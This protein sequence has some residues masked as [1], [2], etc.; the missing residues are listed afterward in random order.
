MSSF[1][2]CKPAWHHHQ[3]SDCEHH[4]CKYFIFCLSNNWNHFNR[5]CFAQTW[6]HWRTLNVAFLDKFFEKWMRCYTFCFSLLNSNM[7]K[8][9]NFYK[10]VRF[11][12]SKILASTVWLPQQ[13]VFSFYSTCSKFFNFIQTKSFCF[14]VGRLKWPILPSWI[15]LTLMA[16]PA[17]VWNTEVS[18]PY[19]VYGTFLN[20]AW[21]CNLL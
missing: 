15:Y 2:L 7:K 12:L 5:I 18:L 3:T 19:D 14:T 4:L 17:H 11:R 9:S 21:I 10:V 13:L 20:R 1:D 8:M 6:K 16:F